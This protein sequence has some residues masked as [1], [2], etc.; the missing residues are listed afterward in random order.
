MDSLYGVE[1]SIFKFIMGAAFRNLV[2]MGGWH[3]VTLSFHTED[4]LSYFP[5]GGKDP[6]APSPWGSPSPKW[7]AT[8]VN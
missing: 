4:P 7:E 8:I 6:N 1:D 5:H 2:F 3:C